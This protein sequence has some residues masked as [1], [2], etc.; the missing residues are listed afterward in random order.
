MF[1]KIYL[2]CIGFLLSTSQIKAAQ[3]QLDLAVQNYDQ[4]KFEQSVKI[5]ENMIAAGLEN[6]NIFYN[7]GNAYYR[8][9]EPGK[10]MAAYLAAKRLLPRDPDIKANLNYVHGQIKDK[11][12]YQT[13]SGLLHIVA[14]WQ[15]SFTPKE[16]FEAFLIFW[17]LGFLLLG[18]FS[19]KQNLVGLK[20][21][22]LGILTV[23][24]LILGAFFISLN[25]DAVWGAVSVKGAPV[26]SGPGE[27][28]TQ[29]FELHQGAPI[30]INEEE[31]EWFLIRLSDEK[32]G[33]I[34]KK[35]VTAYGFKNTPSET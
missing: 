32:K 11:L 2:I 23:A 6:G 7:L 35:Y 21:A 25:Q 14:F 26:R 34:A 13:D 22:G 16:I 8:L 3:D 17:F 28:N 20:Q 4:G 33:W 29:V 18:A 1:H 5:Y 24:L 12:E 15:D 19:W 9:K 27:L 30:I 10:A 31:N